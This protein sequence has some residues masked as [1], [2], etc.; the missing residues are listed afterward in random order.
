MSAEMLPQKTLTVTQI[1]FLFKKSPKQ[2]KLKQY[3]KSTV[4]IWKT[5]ENDSQMGYI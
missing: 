1:S 4:P 5:K 2:R 3:L